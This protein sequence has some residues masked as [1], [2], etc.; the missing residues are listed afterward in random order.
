MTCETNEREMRFS[1]PAS[2]Y[3]Q[4]CTILSQLLCL[5]GICA[6]QVGG[7]GKIGLQVA[8]LGSSLPHSIKVKTWHGLPL[9]PSVF[10]FLPFG[11]SRRTSQA[12]LCRIPALSVPIRHLSA[13]SSPGKCLSGPSHSPVPWESVLTAWGHLWAWA[14]VAVAPGWA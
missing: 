6:T 10:S 13:S 5:R 4:E 1:G 11:P 9:S 14:N 8:V 3:E 7:N 2:Y 12:C